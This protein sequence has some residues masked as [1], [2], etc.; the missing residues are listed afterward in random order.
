MTVPFLNLT[1]LHEPLKRRMLDEIGEVMDQSSFI[2]GPKV[3]N[4]EA[5]FAEFCGV[6]HVVGVNSGTTAL[7]MALLALGVGPGD[8]V[9]VPAM[10][11]VATAEA[12]RYTGATPVFVDIEPGRLCMDPALIEAKITER[13][14]VIMPVHLYG[15]MADMPAIRAIAARHGLR[16]VEDA[17]QAHGAE[18]DGKRAGQWG[19]MACFSF[20]PGKNLGACGEGG[21]VATSDP[22]LD[23]QLRILRDW[24]QE[25]RYNHVR[26]GFN[27]RMDGFQ[28]AVLGVKLEYLEE[29]TEARRA[30]G[31]EYIKRLSDIPGVRTQ[32]VPGDCRHVYHVMAVQVP[33]RDAVQ[34]RLGELGIQ[35]GIHYPFPV[36]HLRSFAAM[37]HAMGDFP[38]A[39][40]L[41]ATELSLPMCPTLSTAQVAEV[42]AALRTALSDTAA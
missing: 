10:T 36:P 15:L 7:H 18:L 9:I 4:F 35:S 37:G 27:A 19:D 17:A 39:E 3:Q 2:L 30:L 42:C 16:V 26:M 33:G 32:A 34:R 1:R 13:T 8:E 21:A 25:G 38:V 29:W 22:E 23:R 5:G 24:G 28:G 41:G 6:D 14:R 31:A 11:F 20:Y 12:V 40:A